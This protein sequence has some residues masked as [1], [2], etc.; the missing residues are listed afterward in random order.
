[1]IDDLAVVVSVRR[2]FLR[3]SIVW[4]M[5]RCSSMICSCDVDV[6]VDDGFKKAGAATSLVIGQV[7]KGLLSTERWKSSPKIRI[8]LSRCSLVIF[9]PA[10]LLW[11]QN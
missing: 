2:G 5:E 6:D 11:R 9:A 10:R 1:V 4:R 8:M 7:P 3:Y